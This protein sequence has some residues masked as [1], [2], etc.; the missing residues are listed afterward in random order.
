[1]LNLSANSAFQFDLI[2]WLIFGVV[3]LSIEMLTGTFHFLFFGLAAFLVALL[4][5]LFIDNL[6]LQISIFSLLSLLMVFVLKKKILFRSL[7]F[8]NDVSQNLIVSSPI[9][10]HSEGF[11]N[12]QGT[13]W[14]AV[15]TSDSDLNTGDLA[16][17]IKTEGNKILLKP[18]PKQEK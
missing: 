12:Y 10:K 4:S 8:Q 6:S 3:L 15:N 1:M 11:L 5:W 17:I 7:G 13:M 18:M 16:Q 14:T 2:I 9:K